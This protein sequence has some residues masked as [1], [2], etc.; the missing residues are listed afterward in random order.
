MFG[1]IHKVPR[2]NISLYAGVENGHFKLDSLQNFNPNTPIY[3]ARNIKRNVQPITKLVIKN[4]ENPTEYEQNNSKRFFYNNLNSNIDWYWYMRPN[5]E[6][7]PEFE[8]ERKQ[9]K[10]QHAAKI[11]SL[12]RLGKTM[13]ATNEMYPDYNNDRPYSYRFLRDMNDWQR[14]TDWPHDSYEPKWLKNNI[15]SLRTLGRNL[16]F[17]LYGDKEST[18]YFYVDTTGQEHPISDYNASILDSKMVF[19]NPTGGKFIGR[20]QDISLPQL[21]S[22]NSWL[23]KNPSW[24][25][26]PDLG[27]FSQYRLD[28]PSLKLYLKQ[29]FEHPRPEDPNV[30][31]VGT[32]EPNKAFE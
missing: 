28:N 13:E 31:T 4:I 21:D 20:I 14:E 11:D 29:Y 7:S 18:G 17:R 23:S 8:E 24:L 25:I 32:T 2:E 26:R 5:T 3:P 30:F 9:T 27:S 1:D 15:D 6:T 10:E 12:L 19:G 22:L 16:R